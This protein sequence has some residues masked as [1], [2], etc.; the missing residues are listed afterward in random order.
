[1][2]SPKTQSSAADL[3]KQLDQLQF[4]YDALVKTLPQNIAFEDPV[5]GSR[6]VNAAEPLKAE[7]KEIK[8]KK[9]WSRWIKI[10]KTPYTDPVSQKAVLLVIETD[11]SQQKEQERL[12]QNISNN[13][14]DFA[15][16][17]SH[18]LQAPL[19]HIGIFSEM[20]DVDYA[21]VLDDTAKEY[22]SE[23]RSNV[24]NMRVQIDGFLR[25]IHASPTGI[26]LDRVNFS[27]VLLNIEAQL[28][29]TLDD[30]GATLTL[31]RHP[32]PILGDAVMIEQAFRILFDNCIKYRAPDRPLEICVETRFH[33]EMTEIRVSDNGLGVPASCKETIFN[34][35]NRTRALSDQRAPSVGLA[36]CKR[37]LLF[38][39]GTIRNITRKRG[40]LFS[41]EFKSADPDG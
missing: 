37:I 23:I 36:L 7:I 3:Q 25:F 32:V 31:P 5:A 2:P 39:G 6:V 41:L 21:P 16:L 35:F 11:V 34:L 9:G 26:K 22:L 20:L 30:I 15:S 19:R 10:E 8:P 29:N 27:D 4:R 12:L 14:D 1:M 18:D 40:A 28:E 17:T 38:H 33:A 13:L 24:E